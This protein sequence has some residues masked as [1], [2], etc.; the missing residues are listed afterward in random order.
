LNQEPGNAGKSL[1]DVDC[2]TAAV[3]F[4]ALLSS[5]SGRIPHG[6]LASRF[7][8]FIAEEIR[9]RQDGDAPIAASFEELLALR[10]PEAFLILL[11]HHPDAFDG[12]AAAIAS[13]LSGHSYGGQLMLNAETG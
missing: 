9:I 4:H 10:D 2:E 6:F 8:F 3:A 5:I 12:A 7:L 1:V 11:A 13:D